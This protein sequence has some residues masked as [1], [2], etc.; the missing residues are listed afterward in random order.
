MPWWIWLLLVLFMIAMIA[1]GLV[2][3]VR[4]ALRALGVV[5]ET[6]AAVGERLA[7]MGES[8][9]ADDAMRA[10]SFTEP[11]QETAARYEHAQTEIIE[12]AQHK[13]N[14]HVG[15]WKRWDAAPLNQLPGSNEP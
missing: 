6:G 4:H 14:R 8:H 10:V 7:R 1:V 2:Y 9:A 13:R 12:R 11:L 15:A 5:S 3:A